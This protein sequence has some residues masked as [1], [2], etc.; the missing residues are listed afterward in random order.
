MFCL[1]RHEFYKRQKHIWIIH[2]KCRSLWWYPRCVCVFFVLSIPLALNDDEKRNEKALPMKHI[3]F[4]SY[5]LRVLAPQSQS[6]RS[7]RT[8]KNGTDE[9]VTSKNKAKKHAAA[10]KHR[11][12]S[13]RIFLPVCLS[14]SLCRHFWL[15]KE[16]ERGAGGKRRQKT[17]RK[18]V[19]NFPNYLRLQSNLKMLWHRHHHPK[20]CSKLGTEIKL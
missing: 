19:R 5:V 12:C 1:C 4:I 9:E 13:V 7:M 6:I 17:W 18:P 16:W 14:L 3:S 11:F 8:S 2:L 20:R 15:D 10:S